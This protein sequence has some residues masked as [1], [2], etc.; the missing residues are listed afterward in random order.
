MCKVCYIFGAGECDKDLLP[1]E[2]KG[3]IIAA[4]GGFLFLQKNNIIPDLLIGDFDS[5]ELNEQDKAFKQIRIKRY[6]SEKDDTDMMLAIKEGLDCGCEKFYIYGGLGGRLDHTIANIQALKY[7]ALQGAEG[8]L[9]G[10]NETIT[11][12]HNNSLTIPVKWQKGKY[13]SV[14]CQSDAARGVSLTNLKYEASDITLT[15]DFP[16]G[17]SN[18]FTGADANIS[19]KDGTVLAIWQTNTNGEEYR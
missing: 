5:M 10:L 3:Y 16:L 6:S 12:I 17:T 19:V 8:Y 7:I 11:V 13:I 2:L 4:D 14:F 15:G 9:I 1:K 18:E